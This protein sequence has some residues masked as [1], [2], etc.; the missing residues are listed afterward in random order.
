MAVSD[1]LTNVLAHAT[2]NNDCSHG[3]S[4]AG[5]VLNWMIA[6]I[7][8]EDAVVLTFSVTLD[9]TFPQGTTHLP[10]V[11]V[12]TGPGSNCPRAE[13]DADCDTDTT[14]SASVLTIDKSNNA[15]LKTLELP[16]GPAANLPTADQGSTVVY[17]LAYTFG[18]DPVSHGVIT[19]VLPAGVQYVVD[20]ASSNDEFSFD[21]YNAATRTLSW[22]AGEG[23]SKSGSVTYSALVL[24]GANELS[25]PLTNVATIDSDQTEPDSDTSA[26]YVPADPHAETNVPTPPPTDAAARAEPSDPGMSLP[27]VLAILGV[28]V[29]SIGI[30]TPVP[31]PIRRRNRR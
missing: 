13:G 1:D 16:N 26:V 24:T 5:N 28:L 18:G 25:Q 14:V 17:T 7:G 23:V 2:Y 15:P 9:A 19:D 21:G 10:N 22:A 30:V 31:A 12:V 11:V 3:C 6:S 20:S 27:L 8:A 4:Q 29:L